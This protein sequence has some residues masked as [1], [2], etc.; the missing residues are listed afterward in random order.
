MSLSRSPAAGDVL[1]A[2]LIL[3]LADGHSYAEIQNKIKH[4]SD[5]LQMEKAVP[6]TAPRWLDAGTPS[7]PEAGV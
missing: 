7:W 4:R 3:M 1:R 6:G 2:R 5:D